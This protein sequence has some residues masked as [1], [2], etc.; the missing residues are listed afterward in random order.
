MRFNILEAE[1]I[2]HKC[3]YCDNLTMTFHWMA[4]CQGDEIYI[5]KNCLLKLIQLLN[6]L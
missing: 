3:S 2:K 4:D 5:C 6:T 1:F